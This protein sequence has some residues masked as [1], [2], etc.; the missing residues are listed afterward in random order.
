[1]AE[2]N[3][4]VPTVPT[5]ETVGTLFA[6]A[7]HEFG[8]NEYKHLLPLTMEFYRRPYCDMRRVKIIMFSEY[9]GKYEE[10]TAMS[11]MKKIDMVARIEKSCLR[12]SLRKAKEYGV[13]SVW[14]NTKFTS[15]YHAICYNIVSNIDFDSAVGSTSLMKKIFAG[16]IDIDRIA[17]LPSRELCQEKYEELLKRIELRSS[18]KI[19]HKFTTMYYCRKCRESK[20]KTENIQTRSG[21]EGLSVLITC[22][23]CNNSWIR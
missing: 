22:L 21:D 2:Q 13:R 1:M 9:L 19:Q 14:T 20:C 11:Y 17:G 15:I 12:E 6:S 3:T 18:V 16:E 4:T 5:V 23:N 7:K 8:M 10:F